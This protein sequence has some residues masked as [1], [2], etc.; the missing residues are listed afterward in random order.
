VDGTVRSFDVR[1]GRVQVDD[2]HHP[3][4]AIRLSNDANC[5]LAGEAQ[6]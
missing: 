5:L 2:I 1:K 6:F 3:V 4:T